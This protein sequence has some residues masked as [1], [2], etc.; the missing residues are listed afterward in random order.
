MQNNSTMLIARSQAVRFQ[1]SALTSFACGA[2]WPRLVCA[3][4]LGTG[5]DAAFRRGLIRSSTRLSK[6]TGTAN[7]AAQIR[8]SNTGDIDY[9]ARGCRTAVACARDIDMTVPPGLISSTVPGLLE[10]MNA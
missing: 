2:G 3:P 7:M 5:R 4:W 1:D 10:M 9:L 8:P 6:L